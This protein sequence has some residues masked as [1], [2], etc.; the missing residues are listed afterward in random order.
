MGKT[1]EP[2]ERAWSGEGPKRRVE[3]AVAVDGV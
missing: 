2:F 1:R 3:S